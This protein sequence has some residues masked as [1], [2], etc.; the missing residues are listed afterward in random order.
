MFLQQPD[1]SLLIQ[2]SSHAVIID[3]KSARVARTTSELCTSSVPKL[4]LPVWT[5]ESLPKGTGRDA[6]PG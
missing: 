6:G 4:G 1:R 2:R 5:A 3:L